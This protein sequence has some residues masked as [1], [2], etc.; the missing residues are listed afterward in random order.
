M[1][2]RVHLDIRDVRGRMGIRCLL[3]MRAHGMRT[4]VAVEVVRAFAGR[5]QT[6]SHANAHKYTVMAYMVIA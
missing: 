2:G 6:N 4:D 3:G 1:H 5:L